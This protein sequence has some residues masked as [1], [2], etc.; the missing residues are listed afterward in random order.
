MA[1]RMGR[2]YGEDLHDFVAE[3]VDVDSVGMIPKKIERAGFRK[4]GVCGERV[5]RA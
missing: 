1:D 4:R 5:A 3:V 2:S